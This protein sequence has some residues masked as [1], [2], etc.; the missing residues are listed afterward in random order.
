[1]AN[2][3]RSAVW[4]SETLRQGMM[5]VSKQPDGLLVKDEDED[6]DLA[7]EYQVPCLKNIYSFSKLGDDGHE[8]FLKVPTF[9]K[10][11]PIDQSHLP[12][13]H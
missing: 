12:F 5:E 3:L 9:F 11:W 1:M 13:S 4:S 2:R 8:G 6:E 7:L 10:S